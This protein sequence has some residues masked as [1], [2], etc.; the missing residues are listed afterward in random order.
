[1]PET[2][3]Q[4]EG[5]GAEIDRVDLGLDGGVAKDGYCAKCR[6]IDTAGDHGCIHAE[7]HAA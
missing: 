7:P 4:C 3:I 5:C 1:M 6:S 2:V